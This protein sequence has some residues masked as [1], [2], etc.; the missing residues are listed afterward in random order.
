MG[1]CFWVSTQ[2]IIS[3][4]S[5]F[6]EICRQEL[7]LGEGSRQLLPELCAKL[8]DEWKSSSMSRTLANKDLEEVSWKKTCL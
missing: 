7:N 4:S 1:L 8:E 5:I 2:A 3:S 6:T